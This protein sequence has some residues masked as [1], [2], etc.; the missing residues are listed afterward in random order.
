MLF[1]M[2]IGSL[3]LE[4]LPQPRD[5]P[6]DAAGKDELERLANQLQPPRHRHPGAFE[7]GGGGVED[8]HRNRVTI[9][10]RG[11]N[12]LRKRPDGVRFEVAVIHLVNQV[13]RLSHAEMAEQQRRQRGLWPAA[14]RFA[15]NGAERSTP[16]PVAA[17]LVAEHV[18]PP[19][20]ARSFTRC[21]PAVRDRARARDDDDSWLAGRSG[22]E[23]HERVVDDEYACL[24]ADALHDPANHGFVVWPIDTRNPQTN[25]RRDDWAIADRFFHHVVQDLLDVQFA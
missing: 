16:N 10:V 24:V 3:P 6:E 22:L 15:Q 18:S 4:L 17:P 8:P 13:L 12:A 14:I 25:R 9:G 1:G 11:M 20:G 21:I 19:A 5:G 2:A 7:L 23:R